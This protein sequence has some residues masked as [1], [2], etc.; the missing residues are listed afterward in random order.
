[1]KLYYK[2][3]EIEPIAISRY[4]TRVLVGIMGNIIYS[5]FHYHLNKETGDEV[6]NNDL[7]LIA[8]KLNLDRLIHRLKDP[9]YLKKNN[10]R[11][12]YIDYVGT[13]ET[14]TETHK[15]LLKM[16]RSKVTSCL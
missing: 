9:D 5:F 4:D 1:M 16:Y 7:K 11:R 2:K 10:M 13:N 8:H 12:Y 15:R 14:L 6:S 3:R